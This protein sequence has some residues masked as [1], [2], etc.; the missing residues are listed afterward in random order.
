MRDLQ[1]MY[2]GGSGIFNMDP[3]GPMSGTLWRK[4]TLVPQAVQQAR[5]P[6]AVNAAQPKGDGLL[7]QMLLQPCFGHQQGVTAKFIR[8]RGGALIDPG[9]C[10]FDARFWP[11]HGGA[12]QQHALQ[13]LPARERGKQILQAGRVGGL[14]ASRSPLIR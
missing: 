2:A 13:V 3:V 9:R 6:G 11:N 8:Q 5:A 1:Q 14:I 4:Q 12:Y 7:W 10:G